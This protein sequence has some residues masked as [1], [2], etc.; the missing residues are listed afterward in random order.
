[1]ICLTFSLVPVRVIC[2]KSYCSSLQPG[3]DP[4]SLKYKLCNPVAKL[5]SLSAFLIVP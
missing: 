3:T 5:S 4:T 1:M 2:R